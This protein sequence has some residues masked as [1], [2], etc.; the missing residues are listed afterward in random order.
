VHEWSLFLDRDGVLNRRVPGGY[1]RTV[2]E[3]E[4]LDGVVDAVTRLSAVATRVV[5][6][7]NQAGVGKG[8]MTQ[9]MLDEVHS[10]LVERLTAVGGRI[11]AVFACPHRVD[12]ACG[13]R[14]PAPGLAWQAHQRFPDIRFERSVMVGDSPSDCEFARA[15]GMRAVFIGDRHDGTHCGA[16]TSAPDLASAVPDL[17]ALMTS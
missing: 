12:D 7:T 3:L 2:E 4:V 8:L 15:A 1:V 5:V 11:D 10:V 16:W 13:C 9:A 6:V 14:K 17:L